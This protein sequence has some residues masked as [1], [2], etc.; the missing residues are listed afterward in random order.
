MPK[1]MQLLDDVE[2][3]K[4]EKLGVMEEEFK[5]AV[6]KEQLETL[7]KIEKARVNLDID[8]IERTKANMGQDKEEVYRG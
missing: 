2:V 5:L 6:A 8:F 4:R 3:E 7:E 1:R